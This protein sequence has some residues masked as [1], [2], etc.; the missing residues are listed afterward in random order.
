MSAQ[1]NFAEDSAT[2][3]YFGL[4]AG[5]KEWFKPAYEELLMLPVSALSLRDLR[6]IGFELLYHLIQSRKGIEVALAFIA[7]NG[8][9]YQRYKD[10]N[11]TTNR[12]EEGWKIF[13][14]KYVV[15]MLLG[16]SGIGSGPIRA[17]L[18][19]RPFKMCATCHR[20][21][22]ELVCRSGYLSIVR[23]TAQAQAEMACRE[24]LESLHGEAYGESNGEGGDGGEEHGDGQE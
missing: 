7:I 14:D 16:D 5:V 13:W 21:N 12:C 8:P 10:C 9:Y 20:L 19:D 24:F 22:I 11:A 2:Q 17:H 18:N 6:V 3:L 23:E 1:P 15:P 4:V